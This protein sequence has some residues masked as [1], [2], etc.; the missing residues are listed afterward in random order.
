M[1]HRR[2]LCEEI[3]E[4]RSA[5][6]PDM[7]K[8]CR[9]RGITN[10]DVHV[11]LLELSGVYSIIFKLYWQPT[12]LCRKPIQNG[13]HCFILC[14]LVLVIEHIVRTAWNGDMPV[15]PFSRLCDIH[16]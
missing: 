9:G 14:I 3:I 4:E 12:D 16:R 7:L 11:F 10:A 1:I 2:S 5:H 15:V 8:P 13:F 6:T